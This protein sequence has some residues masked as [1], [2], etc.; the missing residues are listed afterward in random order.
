MGIRA[1][2]G[3]LPVGVSS[4]VV[5]AVVLG[6]I[7]TAIP[8]LAQLPTGTILGI[9]KDS[10]GGAVPDATVTVSSV[11]TDV[12]RTSTTG[13][14][15]EYRFSAMQPGHYNVKIEK[16]GFKTSTQTN[17]NLDVAQELVV[18]AAREVGTSTQTV[19]VT[20]EAPLVE[21]GT[22]A[23]S[24]LV[25]DAKVAELPLNGRDFVDLALLQPGVT[26]DTNFQNTNAASN[27]EGAFG[28]MFSSNG[29]PVRS[30]T[31][32]LDG[33]L[34]MNFH[35]NTGGATGST[36]GIDGI[37]EFRVITNGFSAEYGLQMGSQTVIVSKGGS[38]QWHG[39]VFEFLRNRD[40]DAR[41]FFDY[42]YETT[43]NRLPQ[44]QRNQFGGSFGGPIRKDKT[45]FYAVFEAERQMQGQTIIDNT[46]PS[47]LNGAE[48]CRTTATGAPLL[49]GNPCATLTTSGLPVG[50]VAPSDRAI[51]LN[52]S[53]LRT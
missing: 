52:F 41:N 45:F 2:S 38:N 34:T 15:G 17:F 39:D 27:A 5:W 53:R 3:H 35:G 23:L 25:D 6:L 1:G 30:N 14:D 37:K 10:S 40:L 29:A 50:T 13:P 12:T 19:T 26:N 46:L 36:L 44:L 8:V 43:G 7:L 49:T 42:S 11:E 22:S 21:T 51:F 48:N 20:G 24:G 31:V 47:G 32:T 9:V 28:V 4:R 16:N 33:A 18:N